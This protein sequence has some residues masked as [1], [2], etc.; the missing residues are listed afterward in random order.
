MNS[1]TEIHITNKI[2]K[3]FVN[4]KTLTLD[5]YKTRQN[6]IRKENK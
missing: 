3:K 1:Q 2:D 5:I 4:Y 6:L